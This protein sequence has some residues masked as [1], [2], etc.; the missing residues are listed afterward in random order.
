LQAKIKWPNDVLIRGRKVCGILI[1]QSSGP[2]VD[3]A[4]RPLLRVV[5][6]IGLN[7][8]QSAQEF[9]DA[10]LTEAASLASCSGQDFDHHDIARRLLGQLDDEYDRLGRGDLATLEAFW[11]GRLGLL[12]KT[13]TVECIGNVER[14][15]L[16]ELAFA[17]LELERPD[18]ELLHLLPEAVRHLHE[19]THG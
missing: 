1:E 5:A 2:G 17:G 8:N 15:R 12:G 4:A 3:A 11:K 16:R 6:G 14:G 13:V 10:G 18:G 19:D 9:A 7:V